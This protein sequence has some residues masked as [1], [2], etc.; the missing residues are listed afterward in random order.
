MCINVQQTRKNEQEES[1]P[2]SEYPND[3][4]NDNDNTTIIILL[5]LLLL[6]LLPLLLL[7]TKV[8]IRS[9]PAP[10]FELV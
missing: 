3:N 6:L 1:R 4:N 7:L 9:C 2:G 5:L 10:S 8:P